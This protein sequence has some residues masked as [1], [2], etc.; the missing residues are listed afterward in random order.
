MEISYLSPGTLLAHRFDVLGVAGRGG[1]GTVYKARDRHSGAVVALKLLHATASPSGDFERFSREARILSELQ[2]PAIVGHVDHGQTV[3]GQHYLAMEWLEGHDLS[4]RLSHGPLTLREALRLSERAAAA[5]AEAHERGVIHRDIKPSN[6]FLVAGDASQ[7]KLLDFG[8]ARHAMRSRGQTRTGMVIGTPEYMSPEQAR[9]SRDLTP[10]AD[11]FSL[12]CVLYE[13]LAGQPP[14]VADHVAAVLVRILFEEPPAIESLRPGLPPAVYALV[15]AL[16]Q[17]DPLLRLADARLLRA[18]LAGLCELGEPEEPALAATMARSLPAGDDFV[19]QEQ[20]LVSIVLASAPETVAALGVTVPGSGVHLPETDRR[21]LLQALASLGGTPD[22]LANGTLLLTVPTLASA[23]DQALLAARSALL[24]RERWPEAT[25]A[26]ATGYGAIRGR[27]AVGQVVDQASNVLLAESPPASQATT[28][29]VRIDPL[30]AKLLAGRFAMTPQARHFVLLHEERDADGARPLLGKPTPCV[31]RETE[32]TLLEA[33]LHSCVEEG[34][35]RMTLLCAAAGVGKSR[36]RHEFLR[37]LAGR[38]DPL[39]LLL[40][41]ADMTEAGAPYGILRSAFLQLAA[42]DTQ[43]PVAEQQARL[44]HRLMERLPADVAEPTWWFLAELCRLPLIEHGKPRLQAARQDPKLMRDCLREAVLTFFAAELQAGP[45]LFALDDLQ[46]ADAVSVSTLEELLRSHARLPLYVLAFARPEVLTTFPRLQELGQL[47]LL[48]MKNLSRK[49][50]ERLIVQV[51]GPSLPPAVVSRAVEQ[52]AGNALFLEELIRAISEGSPDSPSETVVAMLQARLGK[53]PP[54]ARRA[55]LAAAVLGIRFRSAGVAAMLGSHSVSTDLAVLVEAEIIGSS[56]QS[57]PGHAAEYEFRHALMRDAAYGLL[58]SSDAVLG[59]LRAAEFLATLPDSPPGI[60]ADHFERG[61]AG[62]LAARYY[63]RA[64]QAELQ[65]GDM[66]GAAL[67]ARRGLACAV[68]PRLRGELLGELAL[69][70]IFSNQFAEAAEPAREAMALLP[71][72]SAGWCHA[73][74]ARL[75]FAMSQHDAALFGQLVST[76]LVTEPDAGAESMYVEALMGVGSPLTWAAPATLLQ[77]MH[78]RLRYAIERAEPNN[79]G[80]RRHLHFFEACLCLNRAPRPWTLLAEAA[81]A[82]RLAVLVGDHVVAPLVPIGVTAYGWLA[83][84]DHVGLR[85]RLQEM[86]AP[87]RR[88]SD[89]ILFTWWQLASAINLLEFDEPEAWD[90]AEP[91]IAAV[92]SETSGSPIFPIFGRGLS[93]K[94][95]LRRGDPGTAVQ[96]ARQVLP[97]LAVLPILAMTGVTALLQGLTAL[98][99]IDEALQ[100]A[101]PI[102]ALLT[103]LGGAGMHELALRLAVAEAFWA[104]G[105]VDLARAQL[106]EALHQIDLRSADIADPHWRQHFHTH[107]RG[108]QRA[109]LLA[110][111]WGIPSQAAEQSPR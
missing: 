106:A 72:G 86:E 21:L 20:S 94:L 80:I 52:C 95:S 22:F 50:C 68:D 46:W 92:C 27:T 24:I 48:T 81:E 71:A 83:L 1:M 2:H 85:Q 109:R 98:G 55:L 77:A 58:S 54:R 63:L 49:A 104:A 78:T 37:R 96:V 11:L 101:E 23:Q 18:R 51:L 93:A 65:A 29:G 99:Q 28:S 13:C 62:Q 47:Q 17:K 8:V 108:C 88:R 42:V 73:L 103:L 45:M 107:N 19:N 61:G 87:L 79:P 10:A 33:Q 69:G 9:G 26:M 89:S 43:A 70:R 110:Q 7:V 25:V 60:V 67:P 34:E 90:A 111:T 100:V 15:A 32:L 40:G 82:E 30:S 36:L 57:R 3:D 31:G 12:G 76:L 35:A 14:F 38:H 6:L 91:M 56:A 64:T 39:T 105:R 41:R 53:L 75:M 44:A 84:G 4:Q 74:W 102:P 66:A 97:M 16:L 5:V 59:H